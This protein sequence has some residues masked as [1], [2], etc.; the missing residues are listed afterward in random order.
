[1]SPK[2]PP[3]A[4]N[5]MRDALLAKALRENLRR[6][7]AA[8]PTIAETSEPEPQAQATQPRLDLSDG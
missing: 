7:K 1:M 4:S 3:P 8:R 2:Q 6:R 5:P